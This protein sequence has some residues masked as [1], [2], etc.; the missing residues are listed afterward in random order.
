VVLLLAQGLLGALW[1][2]AWLTHWGPRWFAEHP[3]LDALAT[4]LGLGAVALTASAAIALRRS[5]R[6]HPRP[7]ADGYLVETGVYAVLRHPMYLAVLLVCAASWLRWPSTPLAV[8]VAVNVAFYFA[9][10]R[11]EE[12]LLRAHYPDYA[13]YQ[14]RTW[15]IVP[16][17]RRGRPWDRQRR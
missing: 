6:V 9:K 15:G 4:A 3:A 13:R 11:Y 10:S 16:L 5:F 14:A 2:G 17:G 1:I 12:R 8:I 7:R